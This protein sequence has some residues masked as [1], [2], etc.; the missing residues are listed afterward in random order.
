MQIALSGCEKSSEATLTYRSKFYRKTAANE[1]TL[2]I[3]I[4]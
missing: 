4:S 1:S 2:V 3:L